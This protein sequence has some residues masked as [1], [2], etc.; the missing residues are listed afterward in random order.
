MSG[1]VKL[2]RK[3]IFLD[4]KK[5][6]NR[7]IVRS[8]ARTHDGKSFVELNFRSREGLLKSEYVPQSQ[9]LPRN[10][11]SLQDKLADAGYMWPRD[12]K[13]C[14]AILDALY[15]TIPSTSATM[16]RSPG[17][18]VNS[19]LIGRSVYGPKK[20]LVVNPNANTHFG[21]FC[22]EMEG[23]ANSKRRSRI[24]PPGRRLVDSRSL[25]A[26]QRRFCVRSAWTRLA[27]IGTEIHRSE[28]LRCWKYTLL[29]QARKLSRGATRQPVWKIA[30][31]AIGILES[32]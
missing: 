17:W 19:F 21:P 7:L 22:W 13:H 3:G 11:T 28:N 25:L 4:D 1:T 18:H 8:C 23:C 12:P 15:A 30:F 10:K 20:S 26:W 2:S 14:N 9:L 24:R 31:A 32:R 16:V 5:I 6:A 29:L 27:S